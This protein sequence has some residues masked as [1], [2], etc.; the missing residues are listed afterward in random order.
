MADTV[1]AQEVHDGPG[2][3]Q[4]VL[5]NLSD[6]TGESAVTKVDVSALD[7]TPDQVVIERIVY[8]T[9]GMGVDLL[10]DA[11]TDDLAFHIP[12]DDGGDIDFTMGRAW[13]GL[14]NPMS[15]GATGD[16]KLTTQGH[17]VGDRYSVVLYMRKKST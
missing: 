6:G 16:L 12:A 1:R 17:S 14:L 3:A 10:W 11:D 13:Q 15:T 4:Y 7:G 5:T 2:A 8:A 9:R